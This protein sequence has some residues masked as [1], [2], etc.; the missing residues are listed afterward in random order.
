MLLQI[1]CLHGRLL[2]VDLEHLAEGVGVQVG[3][4]V[5]LALLLVT[6]LTSLLLLLLL[7]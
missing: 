5:A 6:V 1:H 2:A 3:Q 4:V 7:R